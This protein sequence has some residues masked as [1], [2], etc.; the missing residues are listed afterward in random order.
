MLGNAPRIHAQTRRERDLE[1]ERERDLECER[2]REGQ[3]EYKCMR[4]NV[5]SVLHDDMMILDKHHVRECAS[6]AESASDSKS[7]CKQT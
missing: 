7:K 1:C 4:Q 2:E 5:R 6:A 3:I